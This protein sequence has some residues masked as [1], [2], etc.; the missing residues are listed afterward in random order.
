MPFF[1]PA[2]LSRLTSRPWVAAAQRAYHRFCPRVRVTRTFHGLR[3]R[4]NINDHLQWLV[5][6]PEHSFE[7]GTIELLSKKW[8]TVWDVGSNFGFYSLLAARA[9]NRVVAFDLSADAI[10]LLEQSAKLNGLPITTVARPLSVAPRPYRAVD[11]ASCQNRVGFESGEAMTLGFREA[12]KRYG[13]PNLIKMDIEGG[14]REFFDSPD[15]LAWLRDSQINFLVE[16]HGV[17]APPAL[18]RSGGAR[19]L[20]ASH[21]FAPAAPAPA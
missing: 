10:A 6:S 7:T 15:F 14:E 5:L 18:L 17:A 3:C 21:L 12:E 1:E 19:E 8:G 13:T 20:D 2:T 16:L 9:G 11:G 4:L